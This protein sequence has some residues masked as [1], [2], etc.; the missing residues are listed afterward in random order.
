MEKGETARYFSKMTSLR[1]VMRPAYTSEMNG[2]VI[3]HTGHTI[4]F[5][6]NYYETSDPEE[7]E[8]LDANDMNDRV[9]WKLAIDEN[10]DS[11]RKVRMEDLEAREARLAEREKA[12]ADLEARAEKGVS[13]G[14][15]VQ[16]ETEARRAQLMKLTRDQLRTELEVREL[17]VTF[18]SKE[19]AVERII[20]SEIVPVV[21]N[22]NEEGG[23]KP[24]Y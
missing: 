15:R 6:N 16:A 10:L 22:A 24:A 5:K 19:D 11:A 17:P 14:P 18:N 4:E 1:V 20:A 9:Y 3:T 8:Y 7:I 12:L 23:D 13:A 21:E 2:R